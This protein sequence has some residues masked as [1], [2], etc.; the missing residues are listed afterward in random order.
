MAEENKNFWS[1]IPGILSGI[2]A[3]LTAVTGSYVAISGGTKQGQA[4]HLKPT[5]ETITAEEL[6]NESE[7]QQGKLTYLQHV[8]ILTAVIDDPDGYT[9]V[10]S[11]KSSSGEVIARVNQN[12]HFNTYL[13]DGNWWQIKTADGKIGYMH[14]SRIKI[15]SMRQ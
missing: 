7:L 6:K 2:A 13:Q 4:P 8:F 1:S 3:I 10:R 15:I 12:E 9:Y 11:I 5:L 14:V